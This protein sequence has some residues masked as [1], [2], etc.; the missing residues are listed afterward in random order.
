MRG[1]ATGKDTDPRAHEG[2]AL[3]P[4]RL[5]PEP[6]SKWVEQ[7]RCPACM[8]NGLTAGQQKIASLLSYGD[9]WLIG[10]S[11]THKYPVRGGIPTLLPD[12]GKQWAPIPLRNLRLPPPLLLAPSN[13]FHVHGASSH[14]TVQLELSVIIPAIGESDNLVLLLPELR[15]V[16]DTLQ[17]DYEILI[18]TDAPHPRT[19]TIAE[20]WHAQVVEQEGPGYGGAIRAGLAAAHGRYLVTMDADLSH[21]P[22]VIRDLWQQRR[23]ADVVIASRYVAGGAAEMPRTRRVLSRILNAVFSRG[24]S[25]GVRD[26]S[27]GFRLYH[28]DAVCDQK[29]VARDFDIL[30][31]ILVQAYAEGWRV[32]EIPF[33]YFPRRHG[34]S[35]ARIFKFGRAYLR[36][37]GSLWKLR[38]SIL[39][40]DYDDRAHDSP[41]AFQRYWQRRRFGHITELTRGEGPVLDVGCGSSRIM[42]ALPA[43]SMGVDILLRKLRYSRRFGHH[44]IHASGFTLPVPD[45]SFSCV[46]C[47]QVIEHVPKESRILDE[48]CRVLAPGGRLVLGT[49]DYSRWQWPLIEKVYGLCAPGGYADEH[50]AHYGREELVDLFTSCGFA[51][52][53]TRYICR[54]ELILAFR[55]LATG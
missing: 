42:G 51:L 26:M 38:N 7:L 18:V 37:F 15:D 19:S 11:C 1:V 21:R 55:K 48:L 30:Q 20:Q 39:S 50:I 41:I 25:L 53:A 43:G 40:A 28:R 27:S 24:L 46:L 44:L 5:R 2:L 32:T 23:E 16:L 47:S 8:V 13:D 29:L 6:L 36:T 45:S 52:E 31:Q 49:P 9:D 33:R 35:H 12:E 17:V 54:G 34:S 14:G 4:I 3:Y 22:T 10:T